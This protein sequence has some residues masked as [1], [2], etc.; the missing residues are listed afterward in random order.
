[1]AVTVLKNIK[2][3]K[4]GNPAQHLKNAI[5]YIMNPEKTENQLWCGSNCGNSSDEIY[6][7]MIDTKKEYAK[8][9]GRQ[10]YH[11]VLS[12][13]PDADIDEKTTYEFGKKF[14]ETYLGE[15]YDYCFAVHNDHE[16]M[17][18]HIV[19]NSVDRISGHKYRYVDGDWE[20]R[21]QPL[22][23]KLCQ[24]FGLPVLEYDKYKR[25]G[26]S[27]VEHMA[28]K[29]GKIIW[30]DIIRADIDA[31]ASRAYSREEF[32][33]EMRSMGYRLRQ[34]N[35]KYYGLYMAYTPP[36]AEKAKRDYKL[37]PGYRL[38]DIDQKIL[39]KQMYQEPSPLYVSPFSA[40][41]PENEYQAALV[42]KIKMATGYQMFQ[43]EIR[44]QARVRKDL[45]RISQLE[46]ECDYL[47]KHPVNNPEE[48]HIR[49][50]DISREIRE[51]KESIEVISEYQ[52]MKYKLVQPDL[53]DEEFESIS[54]AI[55]NFEMEHSDLL[56]YTSTNV[57]SG[58]HS[59][60]LETLKYERTI[61]RRIEKDVKEMQ[62]MKHLELKETNIPEEEP[63]LSE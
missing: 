41:K 22:T 10:G 26:K 11:F 25:K 35:S 53:S 38:T 16:H 27:Y 50:Q 47:I 49:L 20:K 42:L 61:L 28:S 57:T 24:E 13:P 54:D 2:E 7:A 43:L 40:I 55:E 29:N 6:Q 63:H 23:D 39:N 9:W 52:D 48:I 21:I 62:W 18:C 33:N 15:N 31:A 17:H 34:G 36:G 30:S 1:M 60:K 19:F 12:F 45:L 14:C 37:G 4:T 58:E 46:E 8:E 32:M 56:A 3:N 44:E 51:E 59:A 5:N